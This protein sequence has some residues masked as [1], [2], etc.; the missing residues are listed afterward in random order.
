MREVRIACGGS[1]KAATW[2][3]QKITWDSF[4]KRLQ[5]TVYTSETLE[6]YWAM[7]KDERDDAKDKG[8]FVG[9]YLIDG[10]RKR[11]NVKF[12]SFITFDD[13]RV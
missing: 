7:S 12:R 10:R 1:R 2:A 8:A 13:F 6:E 9:G 5:K 3:N 11:E 4:C